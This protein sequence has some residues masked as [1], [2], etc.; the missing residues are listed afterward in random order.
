[1]D[2]LLC[3]TSATEKRKSP[4]ARFKAVQD[5]KQSQSSPHD[6]LAFQHYE[7]FKKRFRIP[8]NVE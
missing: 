5:G 2:R 8:I 4:C 1:M 6:I 7:T 3:A